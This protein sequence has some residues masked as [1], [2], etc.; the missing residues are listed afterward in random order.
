MVASQCDSF[1]SVWAFINSFR[2]AG[3]R[4]AA[5]AGRRP[6][7]EG[8]GRV[9]PFDGRAAA[10]RSRRA[11]VIRVASG[12]FVEMY[13]FMIFGY[14]AD[15]IARTYFPSRD[16]MVALLSALATFGAGF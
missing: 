15:A 14:F 12:N 3:Q 6:G 11:Q 13:D 16:P 4:H 10:I 8:S 5:G 2:C 9:S 7:Y 1:L